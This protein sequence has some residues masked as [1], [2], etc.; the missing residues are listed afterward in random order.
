MV[1]GPGEGPRVPCSFLESK[2]EGGRGPSH[3][4]NRFGKL[5]I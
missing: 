4:T 2:G 1:E 3:A 5:S